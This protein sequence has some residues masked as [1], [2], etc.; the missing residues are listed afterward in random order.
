MRLNRRESSSLLRKRLNK[1]IKEDLMDEIDKYGW[2]DDE[3]FELNDAAK[4]F[5]KVFKIYDDALF[6]QWNGLFLD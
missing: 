3:E 1:I 6:M 2:T 5:L 4:M